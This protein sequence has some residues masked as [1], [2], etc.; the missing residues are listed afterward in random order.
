[1]ASKYSIII[2]KISDQGDELREVRRLNE[3]SLERANAVYNHQCNQLSWS[4]QHKISMGL[5]SEDHGLVQ[6]YDN[7]EGFELIEQWF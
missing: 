2:L 5:D 3:P 1:M 4:R 7:K 6:L